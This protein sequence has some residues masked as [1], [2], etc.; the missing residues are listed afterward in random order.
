MLINAAN[1]QSTTDLTIK[2]S[3]IN[4]EDRLQDVEN[5]IAKYVKKQNDKKSKVA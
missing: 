3:L 1:L 2:A 4:N 5:L